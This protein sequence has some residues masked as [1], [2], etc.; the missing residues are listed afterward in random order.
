L[1]PQSEA[2]VR[3]E[4]PVS[5]AIRTLAVLIL[6]AYVVYVAA[7]TA[8]GTLA[9][10]QGMPG[11]KVPTTLVMAAWAVPGLVGFLI[12]GLT[13]ALGILAA[14]SAGRRGHR[15]RRV[16]FVALGVLGAP[17]PNI[18]GAFL[19]G[20]LLSGPGVFL[21][22]AVLLGILFLCCPVALSIC[23]LIQERHPLADVGPRNVLA[24]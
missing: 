8:S 9:A 11:N 2:S 21:L 1:V 12:S 10:H 4:C 3:K 15:A 7:F 18:G 13:L 14:N 20:G 16:A 6:V 17:G 24:A 23:A 5:K 19:L 22:I